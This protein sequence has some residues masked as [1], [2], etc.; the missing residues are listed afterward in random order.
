MAA[1]FAGILSFTGCVVQRGV[2]FG[3]WAGRAE[4]RVLTSIYNQH[5]THLPAKN[6]FVMI[7]PPMGQ[8]SKEYRQTFQ[9]HLQKEAQQYTPA[10][11]ALLSLDKRMADYASEK[12]LLPSPGMFDFHEVGRLGRLMGASH[13][14]CTWVNKAQLFVPQILS[15]YFAVVETEE[16]TVVLEMNANF[17]ATEQE[18]VMDLNDYLQGCSALSFDRAHLDFIL[19]SPSEYQA[20]VAHE[21]MQALMTALW[22]KKELKSKPGSADNM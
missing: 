11:V 21:C 2:D 5:P 15:I 19:K 22:S 8:I 13:V 1:C 6:E 10:R 9:T 20:F 14:L 7:L 3:H 16:G 17:D 4:N 18:V 12:N